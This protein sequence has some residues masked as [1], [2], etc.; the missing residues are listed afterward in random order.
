MK[1]VIGRIRQHIGW[2]TILSESTLRRRPLSLQKSDQLRFLGVSGNPIAM[3]AGLATLKTL[4]LKNPYYLL[5]RRTKEFVSFIREIAK[6]V[7][8]P[9]QVN[10]VGSMFTV[11]FN[12][13]SVTNY[14]SATQSST[15]RY[16]AFLALNRPFFQRSMHSSG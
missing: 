11:F 13:Q 8:V 12:A 5:D 6:S 4:K 15:K 2:N 14:S 3:A 16:G 9:V 1:W 10:Q 7:K